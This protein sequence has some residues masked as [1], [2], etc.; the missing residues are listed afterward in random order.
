M[1]FM[2][3]PFRNRGGFSDPGDKESI[4]RPEGQEKIEN[5]QNICVESAMKATGRPAFMA[6]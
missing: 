3:S 6:P 2:D 4:F 5:R 1:R